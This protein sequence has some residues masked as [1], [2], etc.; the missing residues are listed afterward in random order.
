MGVDKKKELLKTFYEEK[1]KA[2]KRIRFLLTLYALQIL[3]VPLLQ[4]QS[5]LDK[6]YHK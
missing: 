1:K 3:E 6:K 5:N 2:S 4:I